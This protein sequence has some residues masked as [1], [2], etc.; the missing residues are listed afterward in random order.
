MFILLGD[1]SLDLRVNIL[2][3]VGL[4]Q[5]FIAGAFSNLSFVVIEI[6]LRYETRGLH[7]FYHGVMSAVRVARLFQVLETAILLDHLSS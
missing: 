2:I 6:F 3:E 7:I 5:S 4:G 1:F